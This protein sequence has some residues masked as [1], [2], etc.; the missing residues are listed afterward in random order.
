MSF[1][2]KVIKEIRTPFSAQNNNILI[3]YYFA[4]ISHPEMLNDLNDK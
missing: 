4:L 3:Y 2:I 1:V